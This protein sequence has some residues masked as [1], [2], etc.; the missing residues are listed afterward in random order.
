M[1]LHFPIEIPYLVKESKSNLSLEEFFNYCVQNP[2]LIY[3][4][5]YING[6]VLCRGVNLCDNRYKL[7]EPILNAYRG[8][9]SLLD[10]GAA[11]GYFSFRAAYEYPKIQCVMVENGNPKE[12]IYLH[13]PDMLLNLCHLNSK[14]RNVAYLNK[15]ISL[16]VLQEFNKREHFDV[17]LAFLVIH[18]IDS[19]MEVRR[20]LLEQLLQLG[21]QVVLEVS[22]DVAPELWEFV[23]EEFYDTETHHCLFL[24]EVER[25]YDPSTAYTG[26]FPSG[27]GE[28]YLFSRKSI[29]PGAYNRKE[30][31]KI[32]KST[33]EA[34]N[35]LFP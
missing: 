12:K 33:F 6:H 20:Q 3:Q 1:A 25:Y 10:L 13:H 22:N 29:I 11:Q 18:Q 23:K 27:K 21:D 16:S 14:I 34:L 17:I 4:D 30:P 26:K 2:K 8:Q 5:I 32:K 9:F 7:I 35:G 15:E 31:Q 24:G 19:S 28:F